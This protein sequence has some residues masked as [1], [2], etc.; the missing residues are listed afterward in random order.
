[1][2]HIHEIILSPLITEK[3][4][5]L[6]ETQGI[7]AFRVHRRANKVEIRKAVEAL[8]KVK[9][10]AVRTQQVGGKEKRVGRFTGRRPDWKKAYVK[11]A[12][13]QKTIEYFEVV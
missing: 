2:K 9:V 11:L 13:G 5:V 3:T 12:P 7:L 8:F 4:T 6:K 10:D 1:M